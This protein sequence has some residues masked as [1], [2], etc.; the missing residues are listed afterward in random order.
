MRKSAPASVSE[1]PQLLRGDVEEVG[2]VLA[3]G[4]ALLRKMVGLKATAPVT[5][6][7]RKL[8]TSSADRHAS[9]ARYRTDRSLATLRTRYEPAGIS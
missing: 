8:L 2:L 9:R 6:A 3:A 4:L 1:E 5:S 7:V